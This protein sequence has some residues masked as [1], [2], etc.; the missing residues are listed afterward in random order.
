MTYVLRIGWAPGV[1]P[2]E[3]LKEGFEMAMERWRPFGTVDQ[4]EPFRNMSDIQGEVNRLFDSFLGRR[5]PAAPPM[6]TW[7]P[8][9]DMHETRDCL[10]YTSDAADERSSVD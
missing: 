2:A 1:Q 10:L 3:Q 5:M 8:A 7:L 9:V 4:W 6:R